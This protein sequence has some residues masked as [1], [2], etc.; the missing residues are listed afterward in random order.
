M[1]Y[2]FVRLV[3]WIGLPLLLVVLLIGPSR[4]KAGLK[5]ATAILF[6]RRLDPQVILAQVVR[7][8]VEHVSSVRRALTQSEAAENEIA[9]NLKASQKNVADL[10]HDAKALV[11]SGDE[12]GAKAA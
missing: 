4:V 12:L 11:Q 5:R 3:L 10:E 8:Q 7:Q 2:L 1:A 6:Q 9:R